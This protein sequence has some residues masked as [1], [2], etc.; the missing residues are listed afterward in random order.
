M[1]V[2]PSTAI[3]FT[4]IDSHARNMPIRKI[5]TVRFTIFPISGHDGL[6]S[7]LRRDM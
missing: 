1:R 6:K 7:N 3:P 2:R 5:S 4:N